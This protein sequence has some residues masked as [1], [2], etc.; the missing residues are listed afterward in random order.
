MWRELSH[1]QTEKY[2][3]SYFCNVKYF[4][5]LCAR[6]LIIKV[7]LLSREFQGQDFDLTGTSLSQL[8][9]A[10]DIKYSWAWRLLLSAS[11]WILSSLGPVGFISYPAKS[12]F[13]L[14]NSRVT[15]MLNVSCLKYFAKHKYIRC[16]CCTSAH[17]VSNTEY[18]LHTCLCRLD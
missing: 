9:K 6:L 16:K 14:K 18:A 11:R 2:L 10:R 15:E 12:L 4:L 1:I 8:Q 5:L 7:F 17:R 3:C 13:A